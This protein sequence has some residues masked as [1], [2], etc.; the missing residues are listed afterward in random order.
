MEYNFGIAKPLQQFTSSNYALKSYSSIY[1]F[2][3]CVYPLSSA[4]SFL[5]LIA[6]SYLLKSLLALSWIKSQR[7]SKLYLYEIGFFSNN[8]AITV[9]LDLSSSCYCSFSAK[10]VY[11]SWYSFSI[12]SIRLIKPLLSCNNSSLPSLSCSFLASFSLSKFISV[13]STR[14]SCMAF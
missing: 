13:L 6:F 10:L 5:S 1:I 4:P 9:I 14:F 7:T 2:R 12:Y 3:W 11:D 8:S